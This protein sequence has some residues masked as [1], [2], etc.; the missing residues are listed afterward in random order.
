[1][2]RNWDERLIHHRAA[3]PSRG[4]WMRKLS[5]GPSWNSTS[6][7]SCLRGGTTPCTTTCWRPPSW[8]AAWQKRTSAS[9]WTP[10]WMWVSSM[11]WPRNR[12]IVPWA[13]S[14]KLSAAGCRRWS[15]PS[16]QPCWGHA[17]STVSSSGL[18]S[19][20][21]MDVWEQVQQRHMKLLTPMDVLPVLS[22]TL[23]SGHT[24]QQFSQ[25]PLCKWNLYMV[26]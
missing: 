11:P 6:I 18:Y 13:A 24:S 15:F 14:G 9:W 20:K 2:T 23:I 1:M 7:Q 5:K 25:M 3:L 22:C 17:W 21:G 4:M 12:L 16:T 8:K 19:K 26:V 10:C